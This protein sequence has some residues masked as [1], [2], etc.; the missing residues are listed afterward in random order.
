[1]STSQWVTGPELADPSA[2]SAASRPRGASRLLNGLLIGFA[3]TVTIA[4]AL[5]S[6]YVGSRIRAA[7]KVLPSAAPPTA[8]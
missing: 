4:L 6:W 8:H 1:M 7:D 5:A 3:L 2:D